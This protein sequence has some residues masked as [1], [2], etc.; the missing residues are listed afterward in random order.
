MANSVRPVSRTGFG[1][2]RALKQRVRRSAPERATFVRVLDVLISPPPL[3]SLGLRSGNDGVRKTDRCG[4]GRSEQAEADGSG[5]E[6][7]QMED[8]PLLLQ[9]RAFLSKATTQKADAERPQAPR[10]AIERNPS[11]GSRL[12]STSWCHGGLTAHGATHGSI[13]FCEPLDDHPFGMPVEYLA[14]CRGLGHL[15]NHM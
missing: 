8:R 5:Q 3:P 10:Q 11:P 15:T 7:C 6:K 13:L 2:C 1:R 14:D 9:R 4:K 12:R